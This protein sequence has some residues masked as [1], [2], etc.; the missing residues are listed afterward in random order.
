MFDKCLVPMYMLYCMKGEIRGRTR[1]QKLVFL[2]KEKLK[3]ENQDIDIQFT[4]LYY[5]PFSRDLTD[6]LKMQSK[7]GTV[8]EVLEESPCGGQ[9]FIYKLTPSGKSFVEGAVQKGLIAKE[10]RRKIKTVAKDFGG[11]PL[12]EL[13]SFVYKEYP[14]YDPHK[15]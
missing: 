6:S 13:I 14:E 7:E 2:T 8:V 4:K 11:E 10:V 5:G 15:Q 9:I 12:D 1:F 3:E